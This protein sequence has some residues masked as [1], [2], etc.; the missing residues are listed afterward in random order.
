MGKVNIVAVWLLTALLAVL[1]TTVCV[2]A[3]NSVFDAAKAF[4]RAAGKRD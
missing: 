3:D 1:P 2:A 4:A